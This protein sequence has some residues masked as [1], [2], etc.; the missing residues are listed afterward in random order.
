[1]NVTGRAAANINGK[2]QEGSLLDDRKHYHMVLVGGGCERV[3]EIGKEFSNQ[4]IS[5]KFESGLYSADCIIIIISY[6]VL[7]FVFMQFL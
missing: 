5:F 2:Y 1:M 7:N 6:S 3:Y 4:G